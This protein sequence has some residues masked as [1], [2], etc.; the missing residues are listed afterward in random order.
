MAPEEAE[1]VPAEQL[2]HN[3]DPEAGAAFPAEQDSQV[4]FRPVSEL[5][6]PAVHGRHRDSASLPVLE[7]NFPAPQ[8]QHDKELKGSEVESE[9][10]SLYFPAS[11]TEQVAGPLL[12]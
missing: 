3:S 12:Y 11:Q 9:K 7:E 1:K 6:V 5:A 8:D 2:V 10:G 4:V